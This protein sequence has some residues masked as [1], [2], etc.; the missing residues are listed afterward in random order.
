MPIYEF[1]CKKCGKHFE[2]LVSIGGEKSV[3]C[4]SCGSHSIQKLVSSFGIGG[5]SSR[6]SASSDACTTCSTKTCDTCK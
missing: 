3:S 6:L 5:G 1:I 2:T 4:I